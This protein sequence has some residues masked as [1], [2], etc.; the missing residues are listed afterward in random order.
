MA[1]GTDERRR[2]RVEREELLGEPIGQV[3]DGPH[4]QRAFDE[5]LAWSAA[6]RSWNH[7]CCVDQTWGASSRS[8]ASSCVAIAGHVG[9]AS[10]SP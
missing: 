8:T 3:A 2:V 6:R 9:A 4:R 5:I 1:D 7:G 10:P